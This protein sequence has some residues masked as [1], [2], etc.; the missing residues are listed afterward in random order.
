VQGAAQRLIWY[1]R[2]GRVRDSNIASVQFRS[3][4]TFCNWFK[5]R[6]TAPADAKGPK[7]DPFS[8]RLPRC[9]FNC[10]KACSREIRIFGKDLS[11]RSSTL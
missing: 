9:F 7:Y 3:K 2:Q 1:C 6:F 4:N 11:S 10:G 8:V 5:V